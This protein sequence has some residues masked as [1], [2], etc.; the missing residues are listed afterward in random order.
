[1]QF[2]RLQF[3]TLVAT[4]KWALSMSFSVRWRVAC[5]ISPVIFERRSMKFMSTLSVAAVCTSAIMLSACGG[6]P[7]GMS[8]S[9][10]KTYQELGAPKI[11]YSCAQV[12]PLR[13]RLRVGLEKCQGVEDSV[14][15]LQCLDKY[16]KS[17]EKVES[18]GYSAGVGVNATYNKILGDAKAECDSGDF[19]II[20]SKS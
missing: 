1:M 8:D 3:F 10:Y 15:K 6:K 20:D 13:E 17:A 14:E 5:F 18:I 19:K 7:D 4:I 9:D 16:N 12:P 2:V 11:L